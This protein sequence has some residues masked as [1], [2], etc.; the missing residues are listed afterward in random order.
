MNSFDIQNEG[1]VQ[2]ERHRK[3]LSSKA[4]TVSSSSTQRSRFE[5]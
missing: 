2:L 5:H 3:D 1:D 4:T